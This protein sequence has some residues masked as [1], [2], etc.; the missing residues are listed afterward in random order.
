MSNDSGTY[1]F[2]VDGKRIVFSAT[3]DKDAA[4]EH[5]SYAVFDSQQRTWIENIDVDSDGRADLRTTEASDTS[6][7]TEFR[8]GDRWLE[9]V[10]SAGRTGTILDGQ[11]MTVEQAREKLSQVATSGRLK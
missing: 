5:I 2:G 11:F 1:I 6:V 8:V 10:T 3:T 4:H 7:K 9:R